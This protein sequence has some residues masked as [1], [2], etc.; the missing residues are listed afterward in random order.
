MVYYTV[1]AVTCW[2]YGSEKTNKVHHLVSSKAG[3]FICFATLSLSIVF[4]A[5]TVAAKT[6][7]QQPPV[8]IAPAVDKWQQ[9]RADYQIAK[10]ALQQREFETYLQIRSK[11]T[12]YPLYPYLEFSYLKHQLKKTTS[13]EIQHFLNSY[14]D[15][16]LA[17]PLQ[18][19]W[20][21]HLAKS[22][23]W[24]DFQQEFDSQNK[25]SELQCYALWAT[26]KTGDTEKA[27][28]QVPNLWLVGYSQANA[29]NPIFELWVDAGRLSN[30]MAWQRFKLAMRAGNP[31]LARYLMRFMSPK[32][33]ALA[34][35]YRDTYLHPQNL[36]QV[37]RFKAFNHFHRDIIFESLKRLARR[38]S[39]LAWQLLPNYLRTQAFH[40]SEIRELYQQTL[41]WLAHQDNG[42]TYHET[43]NKH[44]E[45]ANDEVLE[46]GI[47]LSIRQRDWDNLIALSQRLSETAQQS[48][49]TQYWLARAQL[50]SGSSTLKQLRPQLQQLAQ[51][52]DY[53]SFLAADLLKQPYRMNHESYAVDG[54]FLERFKLKAAIVRAR[55][56]FKTNQT[57]DARREWYWATLEFDQNQHYAA[58]H[59]AHQLGWHDQAIRSAVAAKRWHD[60]DLRFPLAYE[61]AIAKAAQLRQLNSNWLMAMARQES[62]MT[63]DAVSHADARGLI[64]ILPGTA[65]NV[66]RKHGISY[67]HKRELFVPKKNIEL[68][69]AYLTTLLEKF[70]GNDIYA[71]AAY[72]AGPHRVEKWLKT[73]DQLPIDVWIESIPF[74]E[75]RKYVKNVL[76][77]SAIY[78]HRRNQTGVQMATINYLRNR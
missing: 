12:D 54:N 61:S 42:L 64:Q 58:A 56:L 22:G 4:G 63:H 28:A 24:Q 49:R 50:L 20:L 55:E 16:P 10:K 53:Y 68:A 17:A 43:L 27:L 70:N 51:Q 66:A 52:R 65:R 73:T 39:Q 75:T 60:L 34:K 36:E 23:R 37:T 77:Y 78:A 48:T 44:P 5:P 19:Q 8:A 76:T 2:P 45:L 32:R 35:L 31:T 29:C 9:Q 47:R 21:R 46:A 13:A 26:H 30:E 69:S 74:H 6:E 67:R 11:L 62:A 25:S 15:T 59:Y 18:H 1:R 3:R 33:E 7:A 38:D 72:N 40:R 71:T 14:R 41:L 57:S